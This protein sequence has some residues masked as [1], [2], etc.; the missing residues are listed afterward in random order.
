MRMTNVAT[1]DSLDK[2]IDKAVTDL[3]ASIDIKIDKAVTDLSEIIQI[4]AQHVDER[5]NKLENR[6]D[7][8]EK[9]LDRLTDTLD[10]FLKR[11]DDIETDNTARDAQLARLERWIEQIAS[12]TGVTL[13]Y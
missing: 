3:S 12:K 13:E 8:V 4:F 11:L 1:L 9:H 7:K 5:F 2:K 10:V 6:V